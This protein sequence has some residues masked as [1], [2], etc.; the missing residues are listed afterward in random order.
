MKTIPLIFLLTTVWMLLP[1]SSCKKDAPVTNFSGH[2]YF[3][4]HL[5]HTVIYQVDSIVK[6]E[7]NLGQIDTF[8][9]QIKEVVESFFTD[10]E[11]RLTARLERYKRNHPSEPWV[12]HKVWTANLL[13]NR[14]EKKEDNI[15]YIKLV[16]PPRLNLRWNG[17]AFNELG[18]QDYVITSVHAPEVVNTIA[19]D[20][21]LTVLQADEDNIVYKKYEVEKYAAG[22]GMI[23]KEQF[24]GN[25]GLQGGNYVL[26]N[27]IHYTEKIISN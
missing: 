3:P 20:S 25:Y 27:F 16:F 8:R 6:S 26:K 9:F 24:N 14:A 18:E 11:G 12:I 2:S 23:Y 4:L 22:T 13:S 7:F 21:V 19:F 10:M 1:L 15:T 17:N 5:G